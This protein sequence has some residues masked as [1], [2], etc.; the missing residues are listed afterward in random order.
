MKHLLTLADLTK[1]ELYDLLDLADSLKKEVKK[2]V[3]RHT[4]E[5]KRLV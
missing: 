3:L 1:E 5:I 4:C 2:G